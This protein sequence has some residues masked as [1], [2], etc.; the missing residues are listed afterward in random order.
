MGRGW[1][2]RPCFPLGGFSLMLGSSDSGL[3]LG[4]HGGAGGRTGRAPLSKSFPLS[5][6]FVSSYLKGV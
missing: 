3:G 5:E 6:L 4:L 1:G 2:R